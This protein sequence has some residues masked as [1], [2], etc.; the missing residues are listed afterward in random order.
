MVTVGVQNLLT[1]DLF[2][3]ANTLGA[4]TDDSQSGFIDPVICFA[5]PD[6]A[7]RYELVFAPGVGNVA[8]APEPSTWAMMILGFAGIGCMAYR[9]KST[10]T[11]RFA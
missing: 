2:V 10:P 1:L 6:D 8:A 3:A 7:L 11:F 4:H 9:R 5:D